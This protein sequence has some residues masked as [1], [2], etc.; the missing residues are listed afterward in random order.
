MTS[1]PLST[2]SLP[3]QPR[4]TATST[5]SSTSSSAYTLQPLQPVPLQQPQVTN[6][7]RGHRRTHSTGMTDIERRPPAQ[8]AVYDNNT[9]AAASRVRVE[10][11]RR[12]G[13]DSLD[14]RNQMTGYHRVEGTMQQKSTTRPQGTGGGN[15]M[16]V[17]NVGYEPTTL[18]HRAA[19]QQQQPVVQSLNT[20]DV[21]SSPARLDNDTAGYQS[22]SSVQNTPVVLRQ[23]V[24]SPSY[25]TTHRV[26]QTTAGPGTSSVFQRAVIVD[27][28]QLIP[29][30][31]PQQQQAAGKQ[32]DLLEQQHQ[33][34]LQRQEDEKRRMMMTCQQ[35]EQ[36]RQLASDQPQA[37]NQFEQQQVV[38]R[39]RQPTGTQNVTNRL[40]VDEA[41]QADAQ[42]SRYKTSTMPTTTSLV[43]RSGIGDR[44]ASNGQPR[45]VHVVADRYQSPSGGSPGIS[46]IQS[47]GGQS[48]LTPANAYTAVKRA[49]LGRVDAR[50]SGGADTSSSATSSVASWRGGQTA[51]TQQHRLSTASSSGATEL[52]SVTNDSSL[53]R[54]SPVVGNK[55]RIIC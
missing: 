40:P 50:R 54:D 17:S 16:V 25:A 41:G 55:R 53:G 11:D 51:Q 15:V 39:Q 36:Q 42:N 32:L 37:G 43:E 48:T 24:Q 35:H 9:S 31:Q 14:N 33:Q 26:Q 45:P 30:Q 10:M 4:Q 52:S 23:R 13:Y 2:L 29:Q 34:L 46:L 38:M 8:T 49:E 20:T 44:A 3:R 6:I 47:V 1:T 21:V 22:S 18:E 12:R 28:A 5:L 7:M 27:S 19:P